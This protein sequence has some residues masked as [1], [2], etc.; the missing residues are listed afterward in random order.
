MPAKR[1]LYVTCVLRMKSPKKQSQCS[2]LQYDCKKEEST[3][4][5]AAAVPHLRDTEAQLVQ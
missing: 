5:A 4:I 2:K 1:E 3:W